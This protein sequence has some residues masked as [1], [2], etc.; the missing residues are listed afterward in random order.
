MVDWV[1]KLYETSHAT[2]EG[3]EEQ[4]LIGIPNLVELETAWTILD[5]LGLTPNHS[6]QIDMMVQRLE[7]KLAERRTWNSK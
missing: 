7:I 1:S 6:R 4:C 2:N 3:N 5:F